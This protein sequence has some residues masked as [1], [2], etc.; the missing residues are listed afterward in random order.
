MGDLE[1]V[2]VPYDGA[3]FSVNSLVS[4]TEVVRIDFKFPLL[5]LRRKVLPK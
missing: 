3:L 2:D 4:Y 1:I 5:E